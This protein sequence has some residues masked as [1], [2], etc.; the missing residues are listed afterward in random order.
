MHPIFTLGDSGPYICVYASW[1][2]WSSSSMPG[3]IAQGPGNE[4]CY[5]KDNCDLQPWAWAVCTFPAISRSTQPST[6]H[7]RVNEYQ[8]SG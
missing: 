6:L 5:R 1:L 7:G 3:C 8:L 4:L 2:Q